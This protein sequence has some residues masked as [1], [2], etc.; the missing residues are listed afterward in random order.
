[1]MFRFWWLLYNF[2][3]LPVTVVLAYLATPFNRKIRRGLRGRRRTLRR[4]D[5]FKEIM[6][7]RLGLLYWFH[8]A[9][10][11]EYE[12]TRPVIEGLREISPSCIIVVSFFSP[13]GYE[14][15][16]HEAVDFM[17]YLPL[18]FPWVMRH[19]L[20]LLK[21]HR[22]V[23]ASYDIW[24]N[25][26]WLCHRE[27][28]QTVLFAARV[29]PGSSKQWPVISNFYKQL[30]GALGSVYTVS[31]ADHQRVKA[32]LKDRTTTVVQ[33]LGNP[34]Y[35]RVNERRTG[36]QTAERDRII[37]LG[38]IHEEDEAVITAPLLGALRKDPTLRVLWAPHEPEP[39]VIEGIG[40][41]LTEAEIAWERYG[42]RRGRFGDE[43]VLI[44]DG[45]GY[46][47]ELYGRGILAYVGGGFGY[48]VHNVMEPA[49]AGIPVLFGPRYKRSHEAEQLVACGGALSVDSQESFGMHLERLLADEN[50]RQKTGAAALKMIEDNLGATTRILQ[51]ILGR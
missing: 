1:M 20:R 10:H 23:F 43:Q 31:E 39:P 21:P 8:V 3:V 4:V 41:T 6:Y 45:V 17:F 40:A 19:L 36:T 16:Q 26:V 27:G 24:P 28:I 29:V 44:I 18:D 32:I 46:L 42:K 38:S 15:C 48:S 13:S 9:S 22:V 47:A 50:V 37:I 11:G 7:H 35:D 49:I 34:R 12:T 33:N 25:L 14:Q 51:A 2:I 30:Y 5:F